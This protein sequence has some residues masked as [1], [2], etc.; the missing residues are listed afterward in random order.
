MGGFAGFHTNQETETDC[1]IK[2]F[3]DVN[4]PLD[5]KTLNYNEAFVMDLKASIPANH[6]RWDEPQQVWK[7]H[8]QY[9]SLVRDIAAKHFPRVE[10]K[11]G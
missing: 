5:V 7:V 3:E 6:R 11:K 9:R 10:V 2:F 8:P 1:T 4:Q